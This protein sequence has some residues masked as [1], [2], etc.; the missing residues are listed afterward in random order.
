[1][2]SNSILQIKLRKL[3]KQIDDFRKTRKRKLRC[4]KV[5]Y[6]HEARSICKNGI[7]GIG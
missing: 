7:H 3:R 4:P 1:M 2:K 5:I 6:Q